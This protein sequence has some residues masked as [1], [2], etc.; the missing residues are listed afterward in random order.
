[1]NP[2]AEHTIL[3]VP[4]VA[5]IEPRT[6]TL[7]SIHFD[8]CHDVAAALRK[9][10]QTG[11]IQLATSA[12]QAY[13]D[14]PQENGF[15]R[16][17]A[18]IGAS[19]VVS[20]ARPAPPHAIYLAPA[21]QQARQRGQLLPGYGSTTVEIVGMPAIAS[22]HLGPVTHTAA[23]IMLDW[24]NTLSASV[25]KWEEQGFIKLGSS[26]T[27]GKNDVMGFSDLLG[28]ATAAV[29]ATLAVLQV[30]AAKLRAIRRHA[31][32]RI[33]MNRVRAD[34]PASLSPRGYNVTQAVFF[35][36]TSIHARDKAESEAKLGFVNVPIELE[37]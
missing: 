5:H 15:Y 24:T 4:E 20:A 33:D 13:P 35:A 3:A 18:A 11:F 7:A 22:T 31:D 14:G 34:P 26:D 16:H 30:T 21:S 6:M 8:L 28:H 1:M 2:F 19:L 23:R 29:G 25:E 27:V 32:G 36:P 17:A 12:D 37:T 10:E 9:W